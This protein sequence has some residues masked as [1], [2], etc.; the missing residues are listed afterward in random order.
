MDCGSSLQTSAG[1]AMPKTSTHF[2]IPCGF[3]KKRNCSSRRKEAHF[4]ES[5][6]NRASLPRLLRIL[7]SAPLSDL[8]DAAQ[9]SSAKPATAGPQ[10]A[11]NFV[12]DTPPVRHLF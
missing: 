4:E 5:H 8:S 1:F 9:R 2:P 12:L 11:M 6:W 10:R 7:E 3:K